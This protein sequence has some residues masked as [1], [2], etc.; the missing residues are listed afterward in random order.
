MALGLSERRALILA[1]LGLLAGFALLLV[2]NLLL[3]IYTVILIFTRGDPEPLSNVLVPIQSLVFTLDLV[4]IGL[5]AVGFYFF[6]AHHDTIRSQAQN[7]AIILTVWTIVTLV[8]RLS[9]FWT[10]TEEVNPIIKHYSGGEY[11][12]FVPHFWFL[13]VNYLGFF[14]SSVLIF[15]VM[16]LLVRLIPNYRVYENFQN[17]NLNLFRTYGMMY[18][19]GA[20]LMGLGWLSFSPGLTG[21]TLGSILLMIYLVAWIVF[22]LMLPI[23]GLWVF[24]PAFTIHRSAVETLKF[25]LLR[26]SER[27]RYEERVELDVV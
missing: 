26:K 2:F 19:V 4:A 12:I 20:I 14:I 25:I 24:F 27:E 15:I 6:G 13:Y 16:V 22:F 11:D 17:V 21:T 9:L 3:I 10:P 7:M 8:W 1:R 18:M 5:L 23:L